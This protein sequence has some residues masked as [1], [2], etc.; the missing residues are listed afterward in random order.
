MAGLNQQASATFEQAA[1]LLS[2]LGRDDTQSAVALFNDWAL[3]L[4]RLGR[5]A[6]AQKLY[7]RAI[8]Y[9]SRG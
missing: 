8:E 5:P 7:R 6:E 2:P 4:D 9:Q 3:A 1:S